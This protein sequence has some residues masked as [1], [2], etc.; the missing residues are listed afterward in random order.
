MSITALT[1]RRFLQ[2][3][4]M[5]A[6]T[7][8]PAFSALAATLGNRMLLLVGTGGGRSG[9][10][11]IYTYAFDPATGALEQLALAAEASSPSFLALSPDEKFLFAVVGGFRAPGA[12]AAPPPPPRVPGQP[13]RRGGN[14]GGGGLISYTFDKAAGTLT[15]INEVAAGRGAGAFVANYGNASMESFQIDPNGKLS[16]VVSAEQYPAAAGDPKK[17]SHPHRVTVSPG[18]GYLMVNDLGLDMIHVYKFDAATAKLTPADTPAW[19]GAP[20]SGP[21]GLRWH[22]NKKI[23]YCVN[24][25]HPTVIVLSWDEKKGVLTQIQE[26]R[27]VPEDWKDMCAPGDIVFDK[28]WQHAYVTSRHAVA[29]KDFSQP[30]PDDFMATFKVAKDGKLTFIDRTPAGGIRPRDC[31]LDPTDGWLLI[32]DQDSNTITVIKR[33]KKTGILAKTVTTTE[34]IGAPMCLI[35]PG[36]PNVAI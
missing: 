21:R 3:T 26:V 23:A 20:G 8:H 35:F 5:T 33:D 14:G 19:I 24:E 13:G 27:L 29:T 34:K 36:R 30:G 12:A 15:Q 16:D 17:T 7:A 4:A 28:K 10:K 6:L 18:N 22:P 2:G 1:R 25:L 32:A 9:S 31:S 11:G